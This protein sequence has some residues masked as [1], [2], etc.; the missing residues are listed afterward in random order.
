[1]M[2]PKRGYFTKPTWEM[3]LVVQ[4]N[5]LWSWRSPFLLGGFPNLILRFRWHMYA[6]VARENETCLNIWRL[7]QFPHFWFCSFDDSDL[8]LGGLGGQWLWCWAVSVHPK[9]LAVLGAK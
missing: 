5:K 6:N 4:K 8:S 9:I 7:G 1:M 2:G 3:I